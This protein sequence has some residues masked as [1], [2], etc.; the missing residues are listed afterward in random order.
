MDKKLKQQQL[1]ALIIYFDELSKDLSN[2]KKIKLLDFWV[3][4]FKEHEEY[5]FIDTFENKKREFMK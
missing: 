4:T 2:E 3:K 1:D 5:E